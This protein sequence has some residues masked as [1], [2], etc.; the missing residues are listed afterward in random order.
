MNPTRGDN[1]P[2]RN[3]SF[4][5][6]PRGFFELAAWGSCCKRAEM[7]GFLSHPLGADLQ[8]IFSTLE[9]SRIEVAKTSRDSIPETQI[10]NPG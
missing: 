7:A 2:K 10:G 6:T 8:R 1:S 4:A 5:A 9:P 3:A